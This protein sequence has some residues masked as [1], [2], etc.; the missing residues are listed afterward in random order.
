MLGK[1]V[2]VR[3]CGSWI[4]V[5]NDYLKWSSTIAPFKKARVARRFAGLSG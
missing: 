4:L 3:Y 5:D 2:Q 1:E